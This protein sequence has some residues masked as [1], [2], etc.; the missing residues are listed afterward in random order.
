LYCLFRLFDYALPEGFVLQPEGNEDLALYDCDDKLFEV[1]QVKDLSENLT[2]SKFKSTFYERISEYCKQES[3]VA[4]T[5]ASFGPVGPEFL[6]ALDN[7]KE[8]P[9]R[10][11]K[12]LTKDREVQ[13]RNKKTRT[14]KGLSND[15]ATNI[16]SHAKLIEVKEDELT[17]EVMAKLSGTISAGDP[18]RAFENLM[19]WLITSAETKRK[20]TRAK[21]I[22]KL[23]RIGTFLSHLAAFHREWN[24]SI[25]PIQVS[26]DGHF[27]RSIL[28]REF[29]LGG[30]VRVDHVAADLDVRRKDMLYKVHSAFES[31][32]VVVIRAASGQGKTTLAY[33]YIL[34]F[35]PQDFRFEALCASDLQ[36]ARCMATAITGHSETLNVPTLVYV[37]VRPGDTFWVEFVRVLASTLDVRVLVTIRE[38]DWFRS[39]VSLDDFRFVDLSINLDES[40]GR[41]I[42]SRLEERSS[43]VK[44]L[45]F[46]DTWAQL[47]ERK[48]L[49]EFVYLITQAESLA[50]K[51]N[52]QIRLL[53][54]AVNSQN[55]LSG[56][57][58]L[59]RLV[60]VASAFEARVQLVPLAEVCGIHEPQRTLERFNNEFLLRT[61]DD[62]QFVEGFHAIRSELITSRLTDKVLN[63][64][65]NIALQALPLLDE[66]DLEAFILSSFSRHPE[67]R[68]DLLAS[69]MDFTPNTWVGIRGTSIALQWLGLEAY[70]C[71][72][73]QLVD[74]VRTVFGSGWWITLDWDLAQA[75]SKGGIDMLESMRDTSPE[76]AFAANAAI[77]VKQQQTDKNAIFN[78]FRDW[79][80]NLSKLPD[81]P[82]LI[83]DFIAL[84]EVMY[85]VGHL[86]LTASMTQ[87]V[88]DECLDEA[89][90]NLP[91]H[92][93]AEFAISA[94]TVSEDTYIRW[95]GVNR[96][97]VEE[98]LRQQTGVLALVEDGDCLVAHY[99]INLDR[100]ASAL[101]HRSANELS[102][103][104]E[105]NELSVE[106]VEI[107]SRCI[108]GY[109]RYGAKGYGHRIS[110]IDTFG[111]DS[112]KRMPIENIVMPWLPEFNSLAR[113]LVEL[114][115][116][117]ESWDGYFQSI[118]AMREQVIIAFAELSEAMQRIRPD[119]KIILSDEEAWDRCK[120][121]VNGDFFLPR[122]AVDE[123]GFVSESRSKRYGSTNVRR[124]TSVSR[125]DP[126]NKA[127][128]EYTRT[129]GNFM[130]QALESLVLIPHLRASDT[131]AKRG[132][133]LAKAKELGIS[134]DS[135]RL[136]VVNGV[137]ACIAIKDLQRCELMVFGEQSRHR[138]SREFLDDEYAA[139]LETMWKWC[140]FAYPMQFTSPSQKKKVKCL[141][142][143]RELKDC[144]KPTVNRIRSGLKALAKSG[145]VA[146]IVSDEIEWD[147]QAALWITF[148]TKH[149]LESLIGVER[150]W[151]ALVDAFEPDRDKIVR[152]KA[153]DLYWKRIVFVPMVQGKS[154]DNQAFANMKGVSHSFSQNIEDQIWRFWPEP[155]PSVA[156]EQLELPLWERQYSW[157]VFD[158][159]AAAYGDMFHHVDH[160][161]D[162][163]RCNVDVDE[164]GENIF[165]DY[166][167][168]EIERVQPMFQES[169]DS[170]TRVLEE[171]PEWTEETANSRSDMYA[172]A[173]FLLEIQDALLPTQDF[174]GDTKLKIAE[175]AE[176]R[177]RLQSGFEL[178]GQAKYLWIADSLGI[179][180]FKV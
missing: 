100:K 133:V 157:D 46:D 146:K 161:A 95:Y 144:L 90:T 36:H 173:E 119:S 125:L 68:N 51:I 74:N 99:V 160:M 71:E 171:L 107:L 43:D 132:M 170:A 38:D 91:V 98:G 102:L 25:I 14:I 113:G 143:R 120:S 111:D 73:R 77:T 83:P 57:L 97:R 42:Y 17:Q 10:V 158:E 162:F 109:V 12:T 39:R 116:R 138:H 104:V 115:F 4:V 20:L 89:F 48:T 135:I 76:F 58:H 126:F 54:D 149:P 153:F 169:L 110:L 130:K 172:C 45:D 103:D 139:F 55:L 23:N 147:G 52:A 19:W 159:F 35:A 6:A 176:W 61:S 41:E 155:V 174:E 31:E 84:S 27:D 47:G 105:V 156:W 64:W 148:D 59:L 180:G 66:N 179:E 166:L 49:F 145:V 114:G 70:T 112:E 75:R 81:T 53:Q 128:N 152:M 7:A 88:M 5:I 15:I 94:R 34:D 137:D 65:A 24:T 92:L 18:K 8:T 154:L 62:G 136:S 122:T 67:S 22:D 96:K 134:E 40:S 101:R 3:K 69:L 164:L 123:W 165:Q 50:A 127:V 131:E 11:I 80:A 177:D 142:R 178:L 33:R 63:P 140:K 29:F 44:Y 151:H 163:A 129:V 28:E 118:H 167:S 78:Y 79:I 30:R 141:P 9:A 1:V 108:P 32:N 175:I 72:N 150:L 168:Q 13:D 106:R 2:T 121:A 124:F 37:D 87:L 117:P 26:N 56:E 86:G 16:L 82:R 93:F 60:A 85:W 21:V